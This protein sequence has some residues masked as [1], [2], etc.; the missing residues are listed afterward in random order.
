MINEM[1]QEKRLA[2]QL[3]KLMVE[4]AI[5]SASELKRRLEEIGHEITTAHA[6]RI[7]NEMP[8]RISIDL[9][10]A[11]M[12][13]LD[14]SVSDLLVDVPSMLE[15]VDGKNRRAEGAKPALPQAKD[16]GRTATPGTQRLL[17]GDQ[18]EAL[19][20]PKVRACPKPADECEP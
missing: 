2:W 13:V 8:R 5:R 18:I 15:E 19:V 1:N 7:V 4:R 17:S 12:T 10:G 16:T 20:G 6:A 3:R 14:C 9:L 11:L